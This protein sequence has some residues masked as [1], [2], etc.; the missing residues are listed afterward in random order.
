MADGRWQMGVATRHPQPWTGYAGTMQSISL[1][2]VAVMLLFPR[3][4]ASQSLRPTEAKTQKGTVKSAPVP[5]EYLPP[6]GMCRIWVDN[7]PANRQPAPT[8]CAT[9][10]R[11]KPPNARVVF[12]PGKDGKADAQKQAPGRGRPDTTKRKPPN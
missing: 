6:P 10:I 8:D 9:A 12:P 11:N 7:V 2:F 4:G 1:L 5:K 3:T